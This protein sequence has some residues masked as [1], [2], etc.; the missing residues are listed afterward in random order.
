[1]K[2]GGPLRRTKPLKRT[3]SLERRAA[4][5]RGDRP[6][7]RASGLRR[8]APAPPPRSL[9]SIAEEVAEKA[10][11]RGVKAGG[12]V[13]CRAYPVS[14]Q[15]ARDF[16]PELRRR[17][18]H[19]IVYRRHLKQEGLEHLTWELERANGV[20][21]CEW[22]HSRQHRAKQRV[23]RQLLPAAALAFAERH[24]VMSYLEREYP[25]VPASELPA[26]ASGRAAGSNRTPRG[27]S[28]GAD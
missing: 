12:C 10:W 7:K 17:E 22:H 18:A 3:G 19:H 25:L 24:G 4:L 1:M 9:D 11:K 16:A 20:C 8:K 28:H 23:P 14:E 2:R 27:G 26:G 6:L 15:V 5:S 21:L 13:M